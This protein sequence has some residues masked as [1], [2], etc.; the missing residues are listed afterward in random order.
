[1]EAEAIR[2]VGKR[3]RDGIAPRTW[4]VVLVCQCVSSVYSMR[5]YEAVLLRPEF[6][7]GGCLTC[8]STGRMYTRASSLSSCTP[9]LSV[10]AG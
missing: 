1:M 3:M 10:T 8:V 7:G 2:Q 6:M 4:A 5:A 9:L